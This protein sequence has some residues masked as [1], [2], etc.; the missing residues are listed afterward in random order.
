MVRFLACGVVPARAT[1]ERVSV[2]LEHHAMDDLRVGFLATSG[3]ALGPAGPSSSTITSSQRDA[4]HPGWVTSVAKRIV[5]PAMR[6]EESL[7]YE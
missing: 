3:E 5:R 7:G 2:Y 1:L 6:P 4:T